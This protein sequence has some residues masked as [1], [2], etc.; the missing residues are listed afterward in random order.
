[1]SKYL[2]RYSSSWSED[3]IRFINTPGKTAKSIYFYLQEVGYFKTKPPYFTERENLNSFLM[4]Y[5]LS[6]EGNLQYRGQDYQI[7]TG[8]CFLIN[9]MEHHHYE[10][11]KNSDWEFLWLHFNG[12][13]A[14]GYFEEFSR[15]GFKIIQVAQP[16]IFESTLYQLIDIHKNKSATTDIITSQCIHTL[17]T[18]LIVQNTAGNSPQFLLPKYIKSIMK[19]IDLHFSEEL[20]LDFLAQYQNINKFHLSHEFKKYTGLTLKEYII[21]TR[22]SHAKDLLKYTEKTVQEISEEC[23]IFHTSH[24]IN[25]FKSREGCTPFVY[26]KEW[27]E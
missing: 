8:Q 7:K 1:M 19:Y 15:N 27:K 20:S 23:G 11:S 13:N 17:L 16:K 3:S 18:E 12:A 9:C 24:F 10:V 4:V 22:L 2:E 6:G 21:T 5:T 14:L 25:L 26:R